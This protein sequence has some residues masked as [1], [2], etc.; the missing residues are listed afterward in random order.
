MSVNELQLLLQGFLN[1]L[2]NPEE[3]L[4]FTIIIAVIIAGFTLMNDLRKVLTAFIKGIRNAII[5]GPQKN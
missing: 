4:R 5:I 1:I 2:S 3:I